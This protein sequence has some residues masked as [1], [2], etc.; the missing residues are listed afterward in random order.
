[1]LL[2]VSGSSTQRL[3][4]GIVVMGGNNATTDRV[5]KSAGQ[6]IGTVSHYNQIGASQGSGIYLASSINGGT[7]AQ[8]DRDDA[9]IYLSQKRDLAGVASNRLAQAVAGPSKMPASTL[10][11]SVVIYPSGWSMVT[12]QPIVAPVVGG[13]S[14]G[15][16]DIDASG[17]G[18]WHEGQGNVRM[19][20]GLYPAR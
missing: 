6:V 8:D 18:Y 20:S 3:N 1:M 14:W 4:T 19:V 17:R 7:L 15:T 2:V 5:T 11:G 10:S 12:G 9:I 16:S 13:E